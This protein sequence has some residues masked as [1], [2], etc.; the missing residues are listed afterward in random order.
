MQKSTVDG[1]DRLAVFGYGSLIWKPNFMYRRRSVGFIKGYVRRFYQGNVT[2]RGTREKPGRVATIIPT[3]EAESRVWGC[4]YEIVGQEEVKAALEH[5]N[6]REVINGGYDF[7]ETDF[8]PIRPEPGMLTKFKA[9]VCVHISDT[10]L[11]DSTLLRGSSQADIP[12]DLYLGEA[13]LEVQASQIASARGTCGSNSDYVFRIASFMRNEV[14]I[15]QSSTD[16]PYI[17]VLERLIL[18]RMMRDG[19]YSTG[20][21]LDDS[22]RISNFRPLYTTKP[23]T[24]DEALFNNDIQSK[25]YNHSYLIQD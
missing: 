6:E 13:P 23:C 11:C 17:F 4:A 7:V 14:P 19:H 24:L 9:W 20:G 1:E 22:K 8:H 21:E 10:E 5:L 18:N 25:H 16:D 3:D 15:E 2:H 12:C